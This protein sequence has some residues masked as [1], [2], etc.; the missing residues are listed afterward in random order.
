MTNEK[1]KS[2]FRL[3]LKRLEAANLKNTPTSPRQLDVEEQCRHSQEIDYAAET[4]H[5][6]YLCIEAQKLIDAGCVHLVM[7]RLGILQGILWARRYYTWVELQNHTRT[8]TAREP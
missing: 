7:Q 3:Y 5:L 4:R 1:L 8:Y 2:V 6:K